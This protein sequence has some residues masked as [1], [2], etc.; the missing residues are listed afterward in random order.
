MENTWGGETD[1]SLRSRFGAGHGRS[2]E[3][4]EL[5]LSS[6]NE[7]LGACIPKKGGAME[8]ETRS[9][10]NHFESGSVELIIVKVK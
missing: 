6:I 4:E 3:D 7:S 8:E 9:E 5:G 2:Q 1:H 10:T